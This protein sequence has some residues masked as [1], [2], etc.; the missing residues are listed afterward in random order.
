MA[1]YINYMYDLFWYY[2]YPTD[3]VKTK[4]ILELC[5][6][7]SLLLEKTDISPDN[8][9]LIND[10]MDRINEKINSCK[11]DFVDAQ[12]ITIINIDEYIMK[13]EPDV[14]P[15]MDPIIESII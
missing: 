5:E 2:L 15:Q 3:D 6:K 9:E 8:L 12:E 10:L 1:D 7:L 11:A 13:A 4:E 14:E